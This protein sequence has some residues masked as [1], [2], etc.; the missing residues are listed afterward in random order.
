M[1]SIPTFLDRKKTPREPATL[2]E[3]QAYARR[4][5]PPDEPQ[6]VS[7]VDLAAARKAERQA[8]SRARVAKMKARLASC[9][10]LARSVPQ[11]FLKWNP[12]R[13]RFEDVRVI[14]KQRKDWAMTMASKIAEYNKLAAERNLPQR[15]WFPNLKA[16]ETA[17]GELSPPAVD[18]PLSNVPSSG[19]GANQ[20]QA[21]TQSEPVETEGSRAF[22]AAMAEMKEKE[23]NMPRTATKKK[24]TKPRASKVL[25]GQAPD[26]RRFKPIRAGTVR[27]KVL[28]LMT[29]GD[30][31]AQQIATR[32][33]IDP[34]QVMAHAYCTH[35]DAGIGYEV[36]DGKL[37]ALYPQGVSLAKAIKKD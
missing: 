37:K 21:Q 20:A 34:K 25:A 22:G 10:S 16:V 13:C 12:K 9:A 28:E 5:R 1:D 23:T 32:A 2:E 15:K 35:R 8:A 3:R 4:S 33:G 14:N 27:A 24:T 17:I 30:K 19:T 6:R 26:S 29:P 31:T 11:E 7:E 36:K 18:T